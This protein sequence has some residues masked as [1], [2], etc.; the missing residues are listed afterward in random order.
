VDQNL[1]SHLKTNKILAI[2]DALPGSRNKDFLQSAKLM[3]TRNAYTL[4]PFGVV[5]YTNLIDWEDS[6][7]RSYSRLIH[8]HT[9]LGCLVEAYRKSGQVQYLTKGMDLI[10]DWIQKHTFET[11]KGTMAY[12]DETTALRLQY[13]LRFYIFAQTVLSAEDMSLLEER[14]WTTAELL[15]EDFFHSTN[16]NHGMFQDMALLFFAAYYD[17]TNERSTFYKQLAVKRLEDYFSSTFTADGVHKEHSPSYHLMVASYIKKL[18]VWMNDIDKEVS[19][20]FFSMYKNSEPYSVHIIRP[21]G[22]LPPLCDTEAKSVLESSYGK[23]YDSNEY[24]YAITK[25]KQGEAPQETDK[26]FAEAG[27]AIFRDDWNKKD[28]STYVLFTAAYNADYHKH[29]DDLNLHIYAG[30]EIITEAGPNGYNYQDPFTKYAYSSFAHNTLVVDGRSLPRTD[31]QY[32]KVYIA[33]Y[34]IEQS[35]AEVTGMNLRYEGVAHKR[36][37]QYKKEQQVIHVTDTVE[38]S[39]EHEYKLLWHVAQDIRVRVWKNTVELFRKGAKVMEI[40]ISASVPA[41][42]KRITGQEKPRVQG[43]VFPKMEAKLPATVIEVTMRGTNV[44]CETEF[45]MKDFALRGDFEKRSALIT[46]T[47]T[48]LLQDNAIT[49]TFHP[50]NA[51]N[52]N[53]LLVVFCDQSSQSK[54]NE[55]LQ[56]VSA[57]KLFITSVNIDSEI[58]CVE[59]GRYEKENAVIALIQRIMSSHSVLHKDV[60]LIGAEK[61][62][63]SALY[64]GAKYHFGHIIVSNPQMQ[65]NEHLINENN[66]SAIVQYFTKSNMPHCNR[67]YDRLLLDAFSQ[68]LQSNINLHIKVGVKGHKYISYVDNVRDICSNAGCNL[69]LTTENIT[70]QDSNATFHSYMLQRVCNILNVEY[71]TIPSMNDEQNQFVMQ[72]VKIQKQDSNR[73]VAKC[74]AKG[75]GLRYAYYVYRNK[76]VIHKTPYGLNSEYV[77]NIEES[78]EYMCRIYVRNAD[79]QVIARNTNLLKF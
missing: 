42:I 74:T 56:H 25:G 21:D 52:K 34:H 41:Q 31:Q 17:D 15:S 33:D 71:K 5:T 38:S 63:F 40:F 11:H 36:R 23:L 10:R 32:D 72:N 24:L 58:P 9:F 30:G 45:R 62:G 73:L 2:I 53:K 57:N 48:Q 28:K 76:E 35:Q 26:V 61:N 4:P 65:S 27:Y 19:D 20:S 13:W 79:K 37:V 68:I 59:E 77:Y 69:Q 14:M 49:Y 47:A 16:T 66:A 44:F 29:S 46:E 64:F 55:H 60:T 67:Y 7:S 3:V 43:W 39:D 70:Q 1:P 6:R 8:G 22:Y 50:A 12:H 75:K 18:V 51:E 78:G 54:Y